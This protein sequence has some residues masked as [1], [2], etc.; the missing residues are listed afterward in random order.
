MGAN[1]GR[2]TNGMPTPNS[3]GWLLEQGPYH[4]GVQ[5]FVRDLNQ[6]YQSEP[7]LWEAD[8]EGEGFSWIDCSDHENSVYSFLRQNKEHT[9]LLL[10]ILNLTPVPR[11]RYRVGLP[12]KG[13][14]REIL[15]SDSEIYVA[16]M[17]DNLGGVAAEEYQVNNQPY[18]A[19]FTLPPLSLVVFRPEPSS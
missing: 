14:W 10:V 16:A 19:E 12:R 18:S 9:R 17:P 6:L 8:Y 5:R 2:A 11:Q 4:R 13:F 1:L 7:A 15:S 3:I